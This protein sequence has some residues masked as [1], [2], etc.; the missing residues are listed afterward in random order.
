MLKQKKPLPKPT[1]RL[2]K[3]PVVIQMEMLECGAASLCMVLAYYGKWLPIEKVRVDSGVSRDGSSAKNLLKAARGYGLEAGGYRMEPSDLRKIKYPAILH[4]NFNHF[5]VLNGFRKDKAVINDPGRG[6]IEV[7]QEILDR[8]FTGIVLQFVPTDQ[9]VPEGKPRSV[10][11]FAWKRLE[12]SLSA[13]YLVMLISVISA[14]VNLIT[15]LFSKVFL[16]EILS[17]R[18][19]EWLAPFS[20]AFIILILVSTLN[21]TVQSLGWLRINGRFA[22][23][24]SAEFMY[25]VLRLPMTFFAQRWAGD[26]ASRQSANEGIASQMIRKLAPSIV[27]LTMIIFYFGVML[28]YNILLTVIGVLTAVSNLFISRWTSRRIQGMTRTL[29]DSA[30]KLSGATVSGIDMIETIKSSGAENGFF[31]R[32]SGYYTKMHNA[33]ALIGETTALLGIV[34]TLLNQIMNTVILMIGVYFIMT[35]RF[36]IGML[37][38]FQ[39]YLSSF[40]N[41]VNKFIN[42]NQILITLK[43]DLERVEDVLNYPVEESPATTG[44]TATGMTQ[45]KLLGELEIRSLTFGYSPLAE[46]LIQ[47]FSL[48]L[49]PGQSVALVGGSGCGKSTLAKLITGLYA[50]W[51][52]DIFI[53]GVPRQSIDP[54]VFRSSVAMVDQDITLF[55]DT[56]SNNIRMWDSTIEDFSVIL[57]ARDSDIHDVIVSRPDGYHQIVQEGGKNFSGGQR[58]RLEI[59]RVLASEPTLIVLDEATSALDSKTEHTVMNNIRNLGATC[60]IVAHRLSTVRDCDEII[61]LDKGR[62]VERGTHETLI[63]QNGVYSQLVT[64]D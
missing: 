23:T 31:E 4:W 49:K 61:V 24:A 41:P 19:P 48:H 20:I 56:V 63:A 46:P 55:E 25:H 10:L 13:V 57:A 12:K 28:R 51:S 2:A 1:S 36:T 21:T 26:I 14:V 9:F 17:G 6:T 39:G 44:S 16:D 50:P 3:V 18:N 47:D 53:D 30:G 32:W 42:L 40:M 38:A 52:G 54:Y 64:T 62:I 7:S 27:N 11:R 8:S 35:G 37:M 43:T 45:G 60:I 29:Q 34:P 15:P 58:Q 33:Q 5:V 59:A 22:I